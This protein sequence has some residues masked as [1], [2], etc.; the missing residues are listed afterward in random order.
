MKFI[1]RKSQRD[2]FPQYVEPQRS[3]TAEA[4]PPVAKD[5]PPPPLYARYA[6][7]ASSSSFESLNA[8]L[9]SPSASRF[10]GY[11]GSTPSLVSH[12]GEGSFNMG[13]QGRA[14]GAAL[15]TPTH[16]ASNVTS[17][18]ALKPEPI[19][20]KPRRVRTTNDDTPKVLPTPV[21]QEKTHKMSTTPREATSA[22]VDRSV[23]NPDVPSAPTKKSLENSIS[24]STSN[25]TAASNLAANPYPSH[26]RMSAPPLPVGQDGPSIRATSS[27]HTTPV[28]TATR[29]TTLDADPPRP[30]PPKEDDIA[31][32]GVFNNTQARGLS[33]TVHR[34]PFTAPPR[35]KAA[36]PIALLNRI[37]RE[38][39]QQQQSSENDSSKS[40][41][42][43]IPTSTA[44][45][46]TA[47]T[48]FSFPSTNDNGDLLVK[49][50]SRRESLQ[51]A[52][53]IANDA[54][55]PPVSPI[56]LGRR[57]PSPVKARATEAIKTS[58]NL[59]GVQ[60]Q[61]AYPEAAPPNSASGMAGVNAAGRSITSP[62]LPAPSG[63]PNTVLM[64]TANGK[65]TASPQVLPVDHKYTNMIPEKTP[66]VRRTPSF[67]KENASAASTPSSESAP[68]PTPTTTLPTVPPTPSSAASSAA[69]VRQ[70]R[71]I[72][73]APDT[74]GTSLSEPKSEA[75][76]AQ[77]QLAS[78]PSTKDRILA[79][80]SKVGGSLRA[81]STT[82]AASAATTPSRQSSVA[83][84]ASSSIPSVS[85]PRYTATQA[86]IPDTTTAPEAASPSR[87]RSPESVDVSKIT[88]TKGGT[89]INGV[90]YRRGRDTSP[91]DHRRSHQPNG[92]STATNTTTATSASEAHEEREVRDGQE[93]PEEPRKS[94]SRHGHS[95]KTS[96]S[97]HEQPQQQQQQQQ[98]NVILQERH[99]S[100]P[101][102]PAAVQAT[103]HIDVQT[104]NHT[105]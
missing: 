55:I 63:T 89:K 102:R 67:T 94:R 39:Q 60:R 76:L 59:T 64:P 31:N 71:I 15:L 68:K 16:S 18:T 40:S 10:S 27:L 70:S 49:P 77:E 30:V 56:S 73:K 28:P 101:P 32:T 74:N 24:P 1:K 69:T 104:T 57:S 90:T 80:E 83:S 45:T 91:T 34:S 22:S 6:K 100:P 14:A 23:S 11:N 35:P 75:Y 51:H 9:E 96:R 97:S 38:Q 87:V 50:P 103:N 98:E 53:K 105:N 62:S 95:S 17:T 21:E 41:S 72:P 13:S 20:L 78:M 5:L 29:S 47:T 26:N 4:A 81:P 92:T 12:N 58:E 2:E 99:A 79:L 61:P 84:A 86:I 19:K 52:A 48:T 93:A 44:T 82:A 7:M 66:L 43:A 3:M 46:N 88:L 25:A 54:S 42:T 85:N 8:G 33:T 65:L 36:P 37:A